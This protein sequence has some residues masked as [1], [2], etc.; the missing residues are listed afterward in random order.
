MSASAIGSADAGRP[1]PYCRFPLKLDLPAIRCESCGA[2]HHAECWNEGRGCAILGC[3]SATAAAATMPVAP[4][5]AE[6]AVAPPPPPYPS[7]APGPRATS[8][9]RNVLVGIFAGVALAAAAVVGFLVVHG[10]SSG[11]AAS[12]PPPPPTAAAEPTAPPS[13]PPPSSE[14]QA[15]SE[16]ADIVQLAEEGRAAVVGKRFGAA[17]ANRRAVLARI[18]VLAPG[19]ARV[20]QAK[21]TFARAMQMSLQ[22][23][24]RYMNGLDA[25][26]T[27]RAASR[28]KRRF[29]TLFDPIAADYGLPS[30]SADDI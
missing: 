6:S 4:P 3:P 16:L 14:E 20:A 27:D 9:T 28:L 12:P 18:R 26:D 24:V 29:V 30:F 15:A 13:P 5:Y 1:C 23:D 2:V 25:T 17:V 10:S 11:N 21:A 8:G 19:S 7:A 22:S